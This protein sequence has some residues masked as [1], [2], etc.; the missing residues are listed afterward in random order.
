MKRPRLEMAPTP[1]VIV[2]RFGDWG[3]ALLETGIG[4]TLLS[5]AAAGELGG[6]VP[7]EPHR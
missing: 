2:Q 5:M 3:A 6:P 1:T 7:G 4:E